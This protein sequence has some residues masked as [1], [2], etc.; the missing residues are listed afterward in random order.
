MCIYI[1]RISKND[2]AIHFI[3]EEIIDVVIHNIFYF[4]L[5]LFNLRYPRTSNS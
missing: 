4:F 1:D 5:F 2:D 3:Y